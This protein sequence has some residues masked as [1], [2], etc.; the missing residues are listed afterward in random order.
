MRAIARQKLGYYPLPPKEAAR[1]RCFLEFPTQ[2]GQSTVL[3]PCVGSG[4]ALAEITSGAAAEK[5]GVELDS[6]RAEAARSLVDAVVQG[7]CFDV[8]CAV[9]TFSLLFLNPPYDFEVGERRNQRMESLFLAHTYR[10]LKPGGVL[11][12]VVPGDRLHTCNDILSVHFHDKLI[13]RLT[14]PEST[15]YKQVVVF[16]V[17]RS[18]REREQL[19]DWEVERAKAKVHALARD[20][21]SL[22]FLPDEPDKKFNIPPAGHAHLMHRGIPLDPV[23]DLLSTSAAYRQAGRILFAPESRATGRPLTPLHGGHIGLLTTAGLLNGIFGEGVDRHVARWESVKVTDKFE[24]T[25]DDGATIIRERERFTQS[26]TLAYANGTTAILAEGN[27]RHEERTPSNGQPSVHQ[28]PS[29]DHDGHH[30]AS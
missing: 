16:G 8:Q 9:E 26:L 21:E 27:N 23:E 17:R 20:Y 19:K 12:L 11:V 6:F 25:D 29:R 13:Y 24:E 5:H 30:V 10:W 15:K 2:A 3:D 18:R 22:P 14:E 1:I 4:A 7:N 28:G